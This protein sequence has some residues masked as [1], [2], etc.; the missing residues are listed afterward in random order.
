MSG[1][2]KVEKEIRFLLTNSEYEVFKTNAQKHAAMFK[3]GSAVLETTTMYDNPNPQYTFYSKEVDGRLRVRTARPGMADIFKSDTDTSTA[4]LTWKQRIPK[5][6]GNM[7]CQETEIEA[8]MS[9][10]NMD[11]VVNI[12]E[13]V[14][15]CPRVSAY[16]R[17]RE[18]FYTDGVEVAS[19][20]FPYGH[21][22]EIEVKNGGTEEELYQVAEILGLNE[23]TPSVKSCDDMYRWLC[24]QTGKKAKN[25]IMF[26]DSDMPTLDQVFG[27]K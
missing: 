7:L 13:N 12:L 8:V 20:T 10:D 19:D 9:A 6:L 18:T 15:R 27:G 11:A 22:V 4:M 17:N 1:K 16:E 26:E 14:L 2:A 21:V 5:Y 24:E 3:T 23:C 25:D